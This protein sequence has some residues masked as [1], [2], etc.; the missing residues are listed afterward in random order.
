MSDDQDYIQEHIGSDNEIYV[1]LQDS[2]DKYNKVMVAKVVLETFV[3]PPPSPEHKPFHL[4]GDLR[5]NC[6]ANLEWRIPNG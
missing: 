2:K 3:G 6:A 5:N 1:Y 4:D